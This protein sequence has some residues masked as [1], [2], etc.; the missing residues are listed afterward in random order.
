M[1]GIDSPQTSIKMGSKDQNEEPSEQPFHAA[2]VLRLEE[3][4]QVHEAVERWH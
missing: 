4:S 1:H 2:I 3:P